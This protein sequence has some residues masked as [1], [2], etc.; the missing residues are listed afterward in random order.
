MSGLPREGGGADSGA[1]SLR[2]WGLP[3][4]AGLGGA[5]MIAE[6][7]SLPLFERYTGLGSGFMVAF[8]GAGLLLIALALA[9]QVR[10]GVTFEPEAGEGVDASAPVSKPGLLMAAAGVALPVLTIP[11]LGF[12]LGAALA[13]ACVTRAYGSTTAVRDLAI[14]LVLSG[15]TWFAFTKL[16]VQLGAFL[17][18]GAR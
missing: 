13:Y 14:G 12:P 1:R 4:F 16:G 8:V 7:T 10:A 15:V 17:P 11:W 18:F 3:L 5:A 6:S 2:D 9:W